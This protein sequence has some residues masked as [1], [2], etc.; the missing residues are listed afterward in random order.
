[1]ATNYPTSKQTFTD[2]NSSDNLDSPSHAGLHA[3][4]N[5]TLEAIQD[6]IGYT[7]SFNFALLAGRAGGQTLIG[8]TAASET[9]T[10]QS[11][12]HGTKGKILFGTSAYDEVN[13]RLG[14]GTTISGYQFQ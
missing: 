10:L 9:L 5:D 13:N 3:D 6:Q 11:T 2:P 8:G 1:M 7:G 4:K 12:S 14:I